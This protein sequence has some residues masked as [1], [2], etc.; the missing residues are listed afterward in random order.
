MN[1]N[2]MFAFV[3]ITYYFISNMVVGMKHNVRPVSG[4]ILCVKIRVERTA[5][6]YKTTP[7]KQNTKSHQNYFLLH[8]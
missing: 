6:A 1:L 2:F 8:S 5:Q 7:V 3:I 4:K